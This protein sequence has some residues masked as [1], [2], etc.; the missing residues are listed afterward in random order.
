MPNY[1]T[2]QQLA[3]QSLE[4]TAS[5]QL[6]TGLGITPVYRV[7]LAPLRQWR[8]SQATMETEMV[9]LS[10]MHLPFLRLVQ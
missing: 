5:L 8:L 1:L 4:A 6:L 2:E 7:P 9:V 3:L 10:L